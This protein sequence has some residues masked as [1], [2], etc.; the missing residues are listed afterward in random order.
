MLYDNAQL[1]EVYTEAYRRTN[2]R[3]YRQVAEETFD[4]VLRDMT[5]PKGGFYSALD[6]ETDGVE[7]K[8][9]VWSREEIAAVLGEDDARLFGAAY[10][11]DQ[12]EFFE[13]GY[14]LQLPR[15]LDETADELGLPVSDLEQSLAAA[16]EK[17]LSSRSQRPA[18]LRD[19]KVITGWNGLM[20][21]ALADGGAAL[22]RPDYT[23][24]AERA[25]LFILS[26]L[27]D[28]NG[29]L[30]HTW[31][32]GQAKLTAYCDDYAYFV[33]GL[34]ALHRA[35]GNEEWLNAA[36]RLTDEQLELFWDDRGH[37]F[38]YT[39]DDHEPL[40]ARAKEAYD[41]VL[42]SANSVS[43][44]NL[45]R[46][47]Q[48]T[49]EDSYQRRALQTIRVFAPRLAESPG[50]LAYL[51]LAVDEYVNAFGAVSAELAEDASSAAVTETQPAG[52]P[53]DESLIVA[54][55]ASQDDARRH[56]KVSAK[57]YLSVDWL[58]AGETCR[59][60][61]VIEIADGWHINANPA[62]PDYLVETE[63]TAASALKTKLAKVVY[64][65]GVEFSLKG[66][67]EPLVV[68]EKRVV[69]YGTLAAPV[70]AAGQTEQLE[71]T[72]HYQT[73]NDMTCLRP[74]KLVL[75]GEVPV[76]AA[77]ETPRAINQALFE[78]ADDE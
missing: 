19:D 33:S 29:R 17:L 44:E 78:P 77:G 41:A 40:L 61:V 16:R 75:K 39:P 35:T 1:A 64:P 54:A 25:A 45:I 7:G 69:L 58:P 68:Y 46:L 4:F 42:P 30:V 48:L 72:I 23:A 74:A 50:G 20:I 8:Y 71:L 76:A 3:T 18:L 57:A 73:C 27:R 47:S 65:D 9:Y 15:P 56:D 34:L 28:R 10:G 5:D 51:A 13:H 49:G 59:V 26:E 14:V 11:L 22:E 67:D 12:P 36:R 24:A 6:A 70:E 66:I 31:R 21:R 53:A 38:F 55:Q 2:R 37:G 52:T 60:A 62:Q 32:A 63:L 43:A